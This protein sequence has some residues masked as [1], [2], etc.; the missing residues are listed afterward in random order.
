MLREAGVSDRVYNQMLWSGVFAVLLIGV[1]VPVALM[2]L[3]HQAQ[4]RVQPAQAVQAESE[5]NEWQQGYFAG[6]ETAVSTIDMICG[7]SG[8]THWPYLRSNYIETVKTVR[9]EYEEEDT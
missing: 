8:Q 4:T 7:R 6:L 1:G 5:L 9:G 2:L 3:R